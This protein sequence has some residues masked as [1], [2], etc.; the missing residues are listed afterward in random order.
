MSSYTVQSGDNLSRIAQQHG[1]SLN[2]LLQAN[3]Q[4][5]KNPNLIHPG[6]KVNFPGSKDSFDPKPAGG[7]SA[8]P[9]PGGAG[10]AGGTAPT[11][12]PQA[13]A[14]GRAALQGAADRATSQAGVPASWSKS[15]ALWTLLQHES[16]LNPR[17][18]NPSSTAYGLF[19]FLDST[20]KTVGATKTSDPEKQFVA[21]YKYIK[22][23]Y[24]TPENAW[25][26][27]QKHHWY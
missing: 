20:W 23:R 8:R 15:P 11:Q 4:F 21:G 16:S 5:Q 17:A 2:Q 1:T 7:S 14:T 25:A 27:W 9:A 10:S 12:A 13:G 6:E 19:Q 3:P 26:F 24:G 18:Q 22:Q